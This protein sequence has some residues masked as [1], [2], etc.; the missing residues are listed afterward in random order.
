MLPSRIKSKKKII[1]NYLVKS[2]LTNVN[3]HVVDDLKELH[4]LGLRLLDHDLGSAFG[5]PGFKAASPFAEMKLRV[6]VGNNQSA[7]IHVFL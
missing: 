5:V 1:P 6:Q 4:H 7:L 2:W 3:D